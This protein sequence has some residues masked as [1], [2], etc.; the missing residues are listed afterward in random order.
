MNSPTPPTPP[1]APVTA[2]RPSVLPVRSAMA[3]VPTWDPQ[4]V[5]RYRDLG[6]WTEETFSEMLADRSTRYAE[7]LAVVGRDLHGTAH[8]WPYAELIVE[9]DRTAAR[10]GTL[11]VR[12]GDR[13]V[14]ALPNVVEF[15]TVLWGLLRL[16]AIPVFALPSHR[17]TELS[18]FCQLA[19][20]TAVVLAGAAAQTLHGRLTARLES[21]P[22]PVIAPLLVLADTLAQIEPD[23]TW[24][25]P[26]PAA[27][28][29]HAIA[30]LQLSG[31]TTGVSKLIPRTHADYLYSVRASA[32][33]CGLQATDRM[34]VVLPVAHN[35]PMSSPGILGVLHTGGAVVLAAD[36]SPRTAFSLIASERV[37]RA[38]LV[39]PLAQAW[40]S[41]ARRRG[42][43]LSTLEVLQVGGAKLSPAIAAQIGPVLG[44]RLQ[45]VFG[46]AEGLVCYTRDEDSWDLVTSSQGRPISSHDEIRI[47]DPSDAEEREVP[48]GAEGALL[49]RG[50]YTI[51]GY[52]RGERRHDEHFTADGFYRTGDLVRALPS[53]HLVVTGRAKDQINRGGEKI[54]TEEI[55]NLL[56]AH[57]G[58]LDALA[59]GLPDPAWGER[60]IAV[61]V[62][63]DTRAATA[64]P[65][66]GDSQDTVA[67]QVRAQLHAH[68]RSS[69]LADFK[70]PDEI[71]L[72]DD[73][74]QTHAGKNSRRELRQELMARLATPMT[75]DPVPTTVKEEA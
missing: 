25:S 72:M 35:F 59:L 13:V 62:P 23:P 55:E 7:N 51:R 49:T 41:A 44:V 73:F 6:L 64:H 24:S 17:E 48:T 2:P 37:T 19:D 18:Q 30:F 61:V 27:E 46:M 4:S 65:T 10:F 74:P 68:L 66:L 69:G 21:L 5:A 33:I 42:P 38:A 22:D 39:P 1:K 3:A 40:L 70:M 16:G 52:Y 56:L 26:E 34:L 63:A 32:A 45:Q 20:A 11:G 28:A 50:P 75:A 14:L 60:V 58:V 54:A 43:D 8:R 67:T 57:P 29:S 31:G 71:H 36:P 47:V 12:P 53:G 9:V 15:M